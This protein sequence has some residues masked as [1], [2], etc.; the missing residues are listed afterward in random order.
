MHSSGWI[1]IGLRGRDGAAA[2]RLERLKGIGDDG[3]VLVLDADQVAGPVC[4]AR[5]SSATTRAT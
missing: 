2:R 3:Q 5:S 1:G 4:G